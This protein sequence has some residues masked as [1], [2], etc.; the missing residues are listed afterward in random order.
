[1]YR[2]ITIST[3]LYRLLT[4][5]VCHKIGDW[6]EDNEIL[7]EMQNGS[8]PDRRIEDSLLILTSAIEFTE[9]AKEELLPII[10]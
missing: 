2:P 9:A 7:G 5:I 6:I 4:K 8:R 10:F 1:M 3:E